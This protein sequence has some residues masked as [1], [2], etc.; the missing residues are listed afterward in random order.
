M[1]APSQC[2]VVTGLPA[3]GKSTVGAQ[4]AAA[5]GWRLLDKDAYLE[6]LFDARGCA[7]PDERQQLSRE[8]DAQFI[9]DA[10]EESRVVLVSH[11]RAR[12]ETGPSGTPIDWLGETYRTIVEVH[13]RCDP[14][15]A[16][17]R[18]R[19]RVRHPGHQDER[20]DHEATLSWLRGCSQSMPLGIGSCLTVATG[21]RPDLGA[22]LARI[23][24]ALESAL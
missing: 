5:L 17:T 19:Q 22:L 13:C 24:L 20:R 10:R 1:L 11:W 16:A 4:L 12:G 3:S 6:A 14:T 8:S 2:L 15:I 9:A 7:T 21:S 18:F 23:D